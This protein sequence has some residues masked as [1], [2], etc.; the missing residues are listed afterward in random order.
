MQ[1]LSHECILVYASICTSERIPSSMGSASFP[2]IAQ[3]F[4]LSESSER[5]SDWAE[6]YTLGQHFEGTSPP[7]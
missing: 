7:E 6:E 2:H 1:G 5:V 3:L 4:C